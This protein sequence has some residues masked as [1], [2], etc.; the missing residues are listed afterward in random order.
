MFDFEYCCK[1]ILFETLE[2]CPFPMSTKNHNSDIREKQSQNIANSKGYDY[3]GMSSF[4]Y[5]EDPEESVR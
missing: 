2:P 1:H 5:S 4:M 3:L